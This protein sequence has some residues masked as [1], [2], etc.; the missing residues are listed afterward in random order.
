MDVSCIQTGGTQKLKRIQLGITAILVV[1]FIVAGILAVAPA[2]AADWRVYGHYEFDLKWTPKE[3]VRTHHDLWMG[4]G[5][6]GGP[7]YA[8]VRIHHTPWWQLQHLRQERIELEEVR[9]RWSDRL[10]PGAQPFEM[11]VGHRIFAGWDA[12]G[13]HTWQPG[14]AIE[15]LN[16]GGYRFNA[17]YAV[18]DDYN[19]TT[20]SFNVV[21]FQVSKRFGAWDLSGLVGGNAKWESMADPSG[22]RY[23]INP[24]KE[25]NVVSLLR[26]R[27]PVGDK[28][29]TV[30]G[31]GATHGFKNAAT[32]DR[33]TP[34]YQIDVVH[35][36]SR[37]VRI[38]AGLRDY[39]PLFDP[40]YAKRDDEDGQDPITLY[41]GQLGGYGL[42]NFKADWPQN[43][44]S[45]ITVRLDRYTQRHK[46]PAVDPD[47]TVTKAKV[48][49]NVS[50]YKFGLG[51]RVD[52]TE[53]TGEQKNST[54]VSVEKEYRI[55]L[56]R[57][58]TLYELGLDK[59]KGADASYEHKV[60]LTLLPS[61]RQWVNVHPYVELNVMGDGMGTTN[62][63]R[64]GTVYKSVAGVNAEAQFVFSESDDLRN[65]SFFKL[66][67]RVGF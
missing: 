53:A 39:H 33:H 11:Y 56:G 62:A 42:V 8:R 55:D 36:V 63:V 29:T 26:F 30:S 48:D 13:F 66:G 40:P 59:A 46:D 41:A 5:V 20:D 61:A 4:A 28:G 45:D 38:E 37:D 35:P 19:A 12:L 49:W 3:K 1:G 32:P 44:R 10:F 2:N 67:Y 15:G 22:R 52:Y 34:S 9:I 25:Y 65:Q 18:L 27:G 57:L 21:G 58:K 64:L 60:R 14:I 47:I 31:F 23:L 7:F 51:H 24:P 17:L 16:L 43:L 6:H 50:G 54:D